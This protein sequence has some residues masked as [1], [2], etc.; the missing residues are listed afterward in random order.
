M[1]II[2]YSVKNPLLVNLLMVGIFILGT[3]ALI[4]MPRELNPKVSFNWVFVIVPYPGAGAVEIE[5]IITT[6]VEEAVD[7]V[8]D[9]NMITGE[10]SEGASFVMITFDDISDQTFRERLNEVES[11]VN[12]IDFPEGALD[13][14]IMDFDSE[15]FLPVIS[16]SILGDMPERE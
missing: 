6:K 11:A 10:S 8:D 7:D 15:D 3:I 1:K 13:P 12:R 4:E 2:E 5:K 9:I 16:V 14:E